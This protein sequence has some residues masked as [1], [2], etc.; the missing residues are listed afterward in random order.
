MIDGIP[1]R[2]KPICTKGQDV[3]QNGNITNRIRSEESVIGVLFV[4]DTTARNTTSMLVRVVTLC[5]QVEG[6]ISML[7]DLP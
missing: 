7:V 1:N 6:M 5:P 4:G 3:G 2:P